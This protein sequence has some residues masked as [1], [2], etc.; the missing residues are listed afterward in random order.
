MKLFYIVFPLLIYYD[1]G[2]YDILPLFPVYIPLIL[3]SE[4]DWLTVG[5][6]LA[7]AFVL[8]VNLGSY[9]FLLFLIISI[10]ISHYLFRSHLKQSFSSFI[11]SLLFATIASIYM[12][13]WYLALIP[14]FIVFIIFRRKKLELQKK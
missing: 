14:V 3:S 2:F 7:G 6:S 5:I 13:I 4:G 8:S 10:L 12:K 9:V 1:L 11:S